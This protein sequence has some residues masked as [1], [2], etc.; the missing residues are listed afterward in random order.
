MKSLETKTVLSAVG[1]LAL[2]ASLS[3]AGCRS[4]KDQLK[5]NLPI[6]NAEANAELKLRMAK[7]EQVRE[8]LNRI[9]D[10]L[11]PLE[12][13]L[14]DVS[15]ASEKQVN[16][17]GQPELRTDRLI[18]RLREVLKKATEDFVDI[19]RDGSWVINQKLK[20]PLERAGFD[21]SL[22]RLKVVG[23]RSG[24]SDRLTVSLQPC[25]GVAARV[26]AEAS[27]NGQEIEA[28]FYP[29]ALQ[30]T[31]DEV[32]IQNREIGKC[33][34]NLVR[35]ARELSCEPIRLKGKDLTATLAPLEF[36]DSGSQSGDSFTAHARI[37]ARRDSTQELILLAELEKVPGSAAK[38]ELKTKE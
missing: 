26:V 33:R 18:S 30:D 11:R 19:R 20:L 9:S 27:V 16:L 36:H 35:D 7:G 4:A 34:L 3:V 21:C 2:I 8:A 38:L 22:S 28:A 15:R 13:L 24:E 12:A 32:V 10:A 1:C 5:T 25:V 6:S 31:A 29:E 23:E 37:E 14:G 17:D